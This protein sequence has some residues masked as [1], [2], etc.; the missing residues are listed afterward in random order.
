MGGPSCIVGHLSVSYGRTRGSELPQAT[1]G[2]LTTGIHRV[3]SDLLDGAREAAEGQSLA[4]RSVE[5]M[6]YGSSP[7]DSHLQPWLFHSWDAVFLLCLQMK[8]VLQKR[9]DL[10]KTM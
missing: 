9:N 1:L 7:Q 2:L 5:A 10:S 4:Y 3:G 8:Q 6:N